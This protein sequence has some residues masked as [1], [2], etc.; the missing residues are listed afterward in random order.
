MWKIFPELRE[1]LFFRKRVRELFLMTLSRIKKPKGHECTIPGESENMQE[2]VISP[3]TFKG[4]IV[5]E[6]VVRFMTGF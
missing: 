2:N 4:K 1:M 3:I 5:C 6:I